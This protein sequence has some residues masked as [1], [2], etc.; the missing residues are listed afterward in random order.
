MNQRRHRFLKMATNIGCLFLETSRFCG[1][2]VRIEVTQLASNPL[3]CK[4]NF[5]VKTSVW[6]GAGRSWKR[7]VFGRPLNTAVWERREQVLTG[8][9]C[10]VKSCVLQADCLGV[11]VGWQT[12]L[13]DAQVYHTFDN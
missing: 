1:L 13:G 8:S 2:L 11:S 4:R 6:K 5:E 9:G 3:V 12:W 7:R 10:I